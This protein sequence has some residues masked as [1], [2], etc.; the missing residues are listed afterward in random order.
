MPTRLSDRL[1]CYSYRIHH[2]RHFRYLERSLR[3][4]TE[5]RYLAAGERLCRPVRTTG[6]SGWRSDAPC[7]RAMS[8]GR[9]CHV[10]T[11]RPTT[12]CGFLLSEVAVI[13]SLAA[14]RNPGFGAGET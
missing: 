4:C 9:R 8:G 2:P 13:A 10:S 5:E 11:G 12:L 3:S 7:I 1:A 14:Y 6:P